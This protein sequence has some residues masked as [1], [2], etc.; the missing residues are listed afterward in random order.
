MRVIPVIDLMGGQVVRGVG[1]R[2]KEYR[3]IESRLAADAQP[4]TVAAAFVAR[5]GF[6]TAYVADLDAIMQGRPSVAAWQAIAAAGLQLWL[7][8]GVGEARTASIVRDHVHV[9]GIDAQ[10]VVGLESLESEEALQSICGVCAPRPPIFSLDLKAGSPLLHNPGWRDW[11]PLRFVSMAIHAGIEDLIVLDLADVGARGGTRT[12]ELCR[13]IR[14]V[15]G[16]RTLIAGGGVRS[17]NDLRALV[18]AGC[19][20]ALVA[21]A[22]HDGRLTRADVGP[23]GCSPH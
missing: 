10:L 6:D 23:V 4:A 20:A 12:L 9:A 7:D 22:L 17:T 5:F 19:D 1:G 11:S 14:K 15:D 13:E 3:P 18:N 2:R 8:A 16:V 21:T